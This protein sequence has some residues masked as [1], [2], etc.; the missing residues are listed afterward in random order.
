MKKK[1]LIIG[2]SSEYT[3]H[4]FHKCAE[5]AGNSCDILDFDLLLKSN[6]YSITLKD[7]NLEI[8]L[9]GIVY[10][11]N[12]YQGFYCRYY[13]KDSGNSNRN[14]MLNKTIDIL[15]AYLRLTSKRVANRPGAGSSNYSKLAHILDLRECG[16]RIPLTYILGD[17]ESAKVV[18]TDSIKWIS[19]GCSSYRTRAVNFDETLFANLD[20]LKY[21]PTLFQKKIT[22][23]DIRVH[24]IG[25]KPLAVKINSNNVD[26]RYDTKN[27]RYEPID[28]PYEILTACIKFCQQENLAFAGFDFKVDDTGL[29]YIL[30]A[31]PMPGFEFYDKHLNNQIAKELYN[32]LATPNIPLLDLAIDRPFIPE[33]RRKKFS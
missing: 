33:K 2:Y 27:N 12:S 28:V 19:K 10:N 31:N 21:G 20:L 15:I 30:E 17:T 32:Y 7:K 16:F 29:W 1:V 22:G 5:D 11:F 24:V 14:Q 18:L 9:D 8:V 4:H 23:P 3:I 26:Y 25:N 13:Y 6:E